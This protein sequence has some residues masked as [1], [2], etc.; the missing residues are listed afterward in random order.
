MCYCTSFDGCYHQHFQVNPK[1]TTDGLNRLNE[2]ETKHHVI[3]ES[4]YFVEVTA[5][6]KAMLKTTEVIKLK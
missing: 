3:H 4:N 5:T 1:I 6:N 2:N